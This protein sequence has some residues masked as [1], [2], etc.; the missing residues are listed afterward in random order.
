MLTVLDKP[1]FFFDFPLLFNFPGLDHETHG[2]NCEPVF[3]SVVFG[4]VSC[5]VL[6]SVKPPRQW[7]GGVDLL[8]IL[9]FVSLFQ[10]FT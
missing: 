3:C 1:N 2:L 6:R 4:I 7:F 10:C 5:N 8:N 9:G